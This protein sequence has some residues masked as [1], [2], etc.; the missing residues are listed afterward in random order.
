MLE[1]QF[2]LFVDALG[3]NKIKVGKPLQNMKASTN[4][5]RWLG[6]KMFDIYDSTNVSDLMRARGV[7]RVGRV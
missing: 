3:V 6:G 4:P 7:P 5:E 1:N 2:V